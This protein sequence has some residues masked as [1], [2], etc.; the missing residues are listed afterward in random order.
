MKKSCTYQNDVEVTRLVANW[1]KNFY[2][3]QQEIH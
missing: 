1:Q 2:Q 3:H